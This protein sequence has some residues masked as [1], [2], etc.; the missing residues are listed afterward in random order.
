LPVAKIVDICLEEGMVPDAKFHYKFNEYSRWQMDAL[1]QLGMR[2][3]HTLLDIGCGP[4]RLG[5]QAINTLNDGNYAGMDAY[6][7]FVRIG[8]K[9]MEA[10]GITKKYQIIL[11]AEFHFERFN[12][13]FDFANAQS[14]FTHLS[15]PQIENCMIEMKKVMK[16]GSKFLFTNILTN[17]PRGFLF[18]GR[19]PMMSGAFCTPDYYRELASRHGITFEENVMPHP[20]QIAHVFKF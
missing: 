5:L 4:L 7:P 17:Y 18:A 10:A 11:D 13:K 8:P 9:F 1:H 6:P 20:T 14:V 2:P 19:Y 15:R 16:P 12:M 3:E